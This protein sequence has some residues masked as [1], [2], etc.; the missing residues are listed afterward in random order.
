MRRNSFFWGGVLVIIGLALLLDNLGV[1]GSIEIW[2]VIGSLFLILFGVRI[3]FGRALGSQPQM[4]SASIPLDGA[5]RARLR[6]QHGAGRLRV[7]SGAAAGALLEG[8]FGGGVSSQVSRRG[9]E[10]DVRLNHA[11]QFFP[12]FWEPGY[13]LDWKVRLNRELPLAL[14]LEIGANE[15]VLE[16]HDLKVSEIYLRSG[17]NSTDI[18]LPAAAGFTR[19][20]ISS[21]AASVKLQ[22]PEGVAAR[23][24]S[25]GGLSSIDVD[26]RRFPGSAG[27]YQSPD[28][29]TAANKVDI[30]VEMGVGS[31]SVR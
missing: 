5:T 21:G 15:A 30:E 27:N 25:R 16:L 4:E 28:Y 23:I 1:F 6:L 18:T 26:L 7:G 10:I 24:K 17:A 22:V 3:L 29:E 2:P 13:T 14:D 9:D 19:T 8:E 20:R 11:V 12:F 31:V